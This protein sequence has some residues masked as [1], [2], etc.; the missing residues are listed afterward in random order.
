MPRYTVDRFEGTDWVVLKDEQAKTFLV[1]RRWLPTDVREGDLVIEAE[2]A[3]NTDTVS[4]RLE[5]DPTGRS[6]RMTKIEPE[7]D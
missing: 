6:E 5:L 7:R 2:Q 4:L 1:P 3:P